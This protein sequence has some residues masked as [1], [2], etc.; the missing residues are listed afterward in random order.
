MAG[1]LVLQGYT[2]NTRLCPGTQGTQGSILIL[3]STQTNLCELNECHKM[4]S[5][6][7]EINFR[8]SKLSKI[9]EISHLTVLV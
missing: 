6:Y 4:L 2:T 8:H 1:G 7:H 5:R 3:K 9:D